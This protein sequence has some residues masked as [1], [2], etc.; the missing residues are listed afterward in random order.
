MTSVTVGDESKQLPWHD[1]FHNNGHD[2]LHVSYTQ[3]CL[4]CHGLRY[5][6]LWV[7]DLIGQ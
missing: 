5:A 6:G 4:P 1:S 3:N 2:C 7:G